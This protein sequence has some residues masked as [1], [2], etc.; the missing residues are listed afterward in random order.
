MELLS[1]QEP[2]QLLSNTQLIMLMYPRSMREVEAAFLIGTYMDL[3]D[4]EV[5]IKQKE[6]MVSTVKGVLRA[7]VSTLMN[8]DVPE[9]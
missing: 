3:V 4:R 6:L 5:V 2:A 8:R 1:E 9:I 7:K